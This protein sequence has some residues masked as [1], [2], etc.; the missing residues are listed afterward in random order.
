MCE[1]V[2]VHVVYSEPTTAG[3][4]PGEHAHVYS[5]G[6]YGSGA[7]MH[8]PLTSPWL[9][10]GFPSPPLERFSAASAAAHGLTHCNNRNERRTFKLGITL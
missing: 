1:P 3:A 2:P 9:L 6:P 10:H 5:D 4:K 8:A 7:G